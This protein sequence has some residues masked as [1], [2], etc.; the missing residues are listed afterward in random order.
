ILY[1]GF[2][3]FKDWRKSGGELPPG[4]T[5]YSDGSA[6]LTGVV[7]KNETGC[8]SSSTLR[9][10]ATVLS[11]NKKVEVQYDTSDDYFCANEKAAAT[12]FTLA[13]GQ[14]IRASGTYRKDGDKY[15][16]NTCASVDYYL[17]VAP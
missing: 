12:G 17:T 2:W 6:T 3:I 9:C 1:G 7:S 10:V 13:T 11:G 15:T 5:L 4:L 16:I 8:R 14:K